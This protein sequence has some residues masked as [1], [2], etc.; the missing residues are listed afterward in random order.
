MLQPSGA[1]SPVS[2]R[3]SGKP[4]PRMP[5]GRRY[6]CARG[7][8]IL[9]IDH[10]ESVRKLLEAILPKESRGAECCKLPGSTATLANRIRRVVADAGVRGAAGGR[11]AGMVE[12]EQP[13]LAGRL[14]WMSAQPCLRKRRSRWKWVVALQSRFK[15]Q[16]YCRAVGRC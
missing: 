4:L 13:V 10:D 3:I 1:C 9:L 7:G 6:S 11:A 16:I 14:V 15:P 2:C 8:R 12:G 5:S